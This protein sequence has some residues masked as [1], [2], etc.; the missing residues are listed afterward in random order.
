MCVWCGKAYGWFSTVLRCVL[1]RRSIAM[2][3]GCNCF[4]SRVKSNACNKRSH[5]C[6]TRKSSVCACSTWPKSS[7]TRVGKSK[8]AAAA[9]ALLVLED[10]LCGDAALP[11]WTPGTNLTERGT[12]SVRSLP[13]CKLGS[14]TCNPAP[15][16]LSPCPLHL[17]HR[18]SSRPPPLLVQRVSLWRQRLCSRHAS[19]PQRSPLSLLPCSLRRPPHPLFL[20]W[21]PVQVV[22]VEVEEVAMAV[23]SSVAAA[24]AMAAEVGMGVGM[25]RKPRPAH[26][27]PPWMLWVS[28]WLDCSANVTR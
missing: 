19:M 8:E 26:M 24:A 7:G 23:E 16:T 4:A 15:W 20:A 13:T 18:P 17:R 28:S 27:P 3:T 11:L 22:G 6:G 14:R 25:V 9:A 12:R 5:G 2:M 21:T 10:V 1:T